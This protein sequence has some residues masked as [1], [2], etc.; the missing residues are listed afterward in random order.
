MTPA[1]VMPRPVRLSPRQK[2]ILVALQ[3]GSRLQV[4][5]TVDGEKRYLLHP[6]DE[7]AGVHTAEDVAPTDV[8]YLEKHRLVESN[9]KFPAATFLMTK[10]G[11]DIAAAISGSER[12]PVGPRSFS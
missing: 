1:R 10:R 5:R 2:E 12:R 6:V 8:A 11:A 3:S 7:A 4:H 9:M